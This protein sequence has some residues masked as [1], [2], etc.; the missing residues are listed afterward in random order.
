M[1]IGK[2]KLTMCFCFLKDL[3]SIQAMKRVEE[4][5]HIEFFSSIQAMKRVEEIKQKEFDVDAFLATIPRPPVKQELKCPRCFTDMTFGSI[6]HEDSSQWD[7][8]CCPMTCFG[9]KCYVT[10]GE[11]DLANY[12]KAVEEQTQPCYIK[13]PIPCLE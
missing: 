8:Y 10:C 7:Y 2:S 13:I 3:P 4:S 5:E 9:T 6:R 11:E 12:L 1:K